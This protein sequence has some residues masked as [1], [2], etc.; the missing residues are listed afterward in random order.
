MAYNIDLA[1]RMRKALSKHVDFEEKKMFGKLAF[2][3]RDKLCL[4]VGMNKMMC[5]VDP[6]LHDELIQAPG[7]KTVIMGGKAYPGY[8]YVAV[9]NVQSAKSLDYYIGLALQF[10]A[11]IT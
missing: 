4:S 3:V 10:N 11:R 1:T 6:A 5:R 9:E 2:M 8:I 7:C